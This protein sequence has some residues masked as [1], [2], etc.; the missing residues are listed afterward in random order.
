MAS[1]CQRSRRSSVRASGTFSLLSVLVTACASAPTTPPVAAPLALRGTIVQAGVDAATLRAAAAAGDDTVVLAIGDHDVTTTMVAGATAVRAAGLRLG[2]WIEVGHCERLAD[3][4]PEWVAS[5]QGHGEWRQNAPDFAEPPADQVVIA[6]PWVPVRYAEAFAAHQQRVAAQLR[7]LPPADFVFLNDLQGPPAACGCGNVLCRWATDYTLHGQPPAREATLLPP[8]A[9][10]RFVAGVQTL[11]PASLVIPVWVTECE[12]ADTTADGA[13]HGVG[14]YHGACW[15]EFDRQWV[16]LRD[17][18]SHIALCLT[19][20]T[21]GRDL[22]RYDDQ[23]GWVAFASAHLRERAKSHHGG[24]LAATRLVAIVDDDGT[25]KGVAM[26]RAAGITAIL[27]LRV[28]ID[29]TFQP[30]LRA[31]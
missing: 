5:L 12:E 26:A 22:P 21:F 15:R 16:P 27:V 8:D 13:C 24:E 10:A 14:C 28:G 30:R 18:C 31:R 17:H 3:A 1:R 7:A 6:W 20:R 9:A 4:H 23:A 29:A 19:W 25:G 11:V 2:Y